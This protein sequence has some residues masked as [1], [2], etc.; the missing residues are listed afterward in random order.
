MG[1]A[2]YLE[3]RGLGSVLFILQSGIAGALLQQTWGG[4]APGVPEP[5]RGLCTFSQEEAQAFR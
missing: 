5:V 2:L 3:S 1:P 4:P